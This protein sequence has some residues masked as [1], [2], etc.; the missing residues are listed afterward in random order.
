[1]ISLSPDLMW[2]LGAIE[3]PALAA[4]AGLVLR[5]RAE[6]AA[7]QGALRDALE[8]RTAQLRE[9]LAAFKLEAAKTYAGHGD[10]R[11]AEGRLVAH[12]LRIEAKLDKTAL[13]AARLEKS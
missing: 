5:T 9:A 3:I 7:A 8:T 1:M 11:A 10:L 2:W 6:H 13:T 12:L 4:L